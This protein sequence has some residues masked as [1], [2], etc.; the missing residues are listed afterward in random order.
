MNFYTK[1]NTVLLKAKKS[2]Q[3]AGFKVL[4][5]YYRVN[6][7]VIKYIKAAISAETGMVSTHAQSRLMVTPHLTADTRLVIPTPIIEPVIV[8]VVETG[9]PRCSEV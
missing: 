4:K 8:C 1:I 3:S 6:S 7:V 2:R 9:I 5:G